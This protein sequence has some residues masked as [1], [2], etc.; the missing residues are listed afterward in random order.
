MAWVVASSEPMMRGR[1]YF[2][3]DG[4]ALP[5]LEALEKY[6]LPIRRADG[7]SRLQ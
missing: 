1:G 2:D 3:A 6:A 5:I 7:Q 4:N